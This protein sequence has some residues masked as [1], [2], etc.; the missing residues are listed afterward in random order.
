MSV[1][2]SQGD[3]ETNKHANNQTVNGDQDRAVGEAKGERT[4]CGALEAT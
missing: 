3:A 1:F 4:D 2:K